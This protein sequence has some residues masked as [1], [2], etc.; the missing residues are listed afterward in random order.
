MTW[1]L[2]ALLL[3]VP[4]SEV[5]RDRAPL[6]P[7]IPWSQSVTWSRTVDLGMAV[8]SPKYLS[9]IGS[10]QT[11]IL[12]ISLV[13]GSV[14]TRVPVDEASRAFWRAITLAFPAVCDQ[15]GSRP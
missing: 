14:E 12:R 1:L 2:L 3:T 11:E 4:T 7:T 15:R 9:L 5:L 10:S 8:T 13:D 6:A